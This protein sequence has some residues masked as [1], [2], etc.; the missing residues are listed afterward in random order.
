[1]NQRGVVINQRVAEER[2]NA[3]AAN[4]GKL[5]VWEVAC[6]GLVGWLIRE[7]T[8]PECHSH[9][10]GQGRSGCV[11]WASCALPSRSRARPN[12][13]EPLR[14]WCLEPCTSWSRHKSTHR[15][16]LRSASPPKRAP[17]AMSTTRGAC[18]AASQTRA[19]PFQARS[20]HHPAHVVGWLARWLVGQEG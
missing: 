19:S 18:A 20:S 5:M 9:H 15:L 1:M 12:M 16:Q 8:V 2:A 4:A 7:L 6:A 14:L 11:H 3:D 13:V 10:K 17:W